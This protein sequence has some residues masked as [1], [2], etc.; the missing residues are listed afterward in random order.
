MLAPA[1]EIIENEAMAMYFL[2][3]KDVRDLTPTLLDETGQLR[4]VAAAELASTSPEERL[5]FGARHGF[6]GLPT[7]ELCA[8][9]RQRI[10]GRSAIEIGAGHG[11]LAAELGIPATDNWQQEEPALKAHYARIKQATV[12]YGAHV[13]KLSAAEAVAKYKPQVVVA[14]WVTHL[15]DPAR[16]EAE[17]SVFGVDEE[18][19]LASCDEYI[20]IGNE[21][22]HRGKAIWTR[23]HERLTPPWL[24]SRAANGSPDFIAIWRRARD[25]NACGA[26][27]PASV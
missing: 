18:S 13:E 17:G 14:C 7:K 23:P 19:I 10:A 21:H 27:A 15:Y 3:P 8:F 4:I 25:S 20:L 16:P 22:V 6:Y 1:R 5:L 24:Y 26:C 11:R 12:P 2:D 9:L